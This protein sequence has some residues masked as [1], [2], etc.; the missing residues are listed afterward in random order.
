[1][2]FSQ[3]QILSASITKGVKAN[4]ETDGP[5]VIQ[6][7]L[8]PL[9]KCWSHEASRNSVSEVHGMKALKIVGIFFGG[10]VFGGFL[11]GW[12]AWRVYSMQMVSKE[13]DLAFNACEQAEWLALLRLDET[14]AAIK[15]M[16]NS[17]DIAVSTL[18]QWAEVTTPPET[19]RL[20][21]D[22]FLIPVKVY[23]ESYPSVGDEAA[24][25]NS[26][27]A[28]VPDRNLRKECKSGIC[29]LDDLR[30]AAA[31]STNAPPK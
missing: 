4:L 3:D 5:F 7:P 15:Q 10:I 14:A 20:R 29:R 25:V 11:V 12:Y 16:E 21:R 22:R 30:R 8:A 17:T 27:L 2:E 9:V 13:V 18:Q 31:A 26:L 6:T 23:H 24:A 19:I 28:T 1:M